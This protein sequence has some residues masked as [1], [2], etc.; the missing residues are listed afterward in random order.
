METRHAKPCIFSCIWFR[1]VVPGTQHEPAV[2]VGRQTHNNRDSI[3]AS[4]VIREHAAYVQIIL[5]FS[6]HK[7]TA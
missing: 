6:L 1:S 7:A 4:S 3:L 2:Q 5:S